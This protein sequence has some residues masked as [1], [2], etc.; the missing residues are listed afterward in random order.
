MS[1]HG[2]LFRRNRARRSILVACLAVCLLP[3][4]LLAAA[5]ANADSAL[6]RSGRVDTPESSPND[7]TVVYT[8]IVQ[9]LVAGR[10]KATVR[11]ASATPAPSRYVWVYVGEYSG[12]SCQVRAV[13]AG[14][15]ATNDAAGSFYGGDA[16]GVSRTRS[17]ATM[18]LTSAV[19]AQFGTAAYDCAW[20]QIWNSDHTSMLQDFEVAD[21]ETN[22]RPK[23]TIGG[24]AEKLQAAA[25]GRWVTMRMEVYNAG[26]S[27]GFGVKITAS[28]KGLKIKR[29][30]HS[31]GSIGDGITKRATFK[32]RVKKGTKKHKVTFK[33]T[34]TGG[35]TVKRT[36]TIGVA[37][38]PK[39][40][41]SLA[42]RYFWGFA[43]TSIADY[44]GWD[45]QVMW[46]LNNRWVHFGET[47]GGAVPKCRKVNRA[48]KTYTYNPRTGVAKIGKVKFK[49]SSYGY[50][51][52]A[53]DQKKRYYEA[54]T[55]PKKGKR[56]ATSLL[57]RDWYGNCIMTCTSFTNYL[58]MDRK[59]R[60]QRGGYS[61]GSWPALGWSWSTIPPNQRGKY[62]IISKG[63]IEFRYADGRRVRSRI[64]L[65]HN[66]LN[67][68]SAAS[69]I[70][71]GA[72]NYYKG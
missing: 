35:K 15:S 65:M 9:D 52:K 48:C 59:G 36:Y 55:F 66:A 18:T 34:A 8:D 72:T 7:G 42:G 60:F 64:A 12:S 30:S 54:V 63:R 68:P 69:G 13:F 24:P 43:S 58:T 70:V 32:V 5:P 21:L 37:P 45:N 17:G 29:K 51:Y 40:F 6:S 14:G 71:L 19:Q 1:L 23:L 10:L 22:W 53:P 50:V 11:F 47:K 33:V 16:F 41:K 4:T 25:K 62:R 3:F 56:F 27:D 38:K 39:R 57:N 2:Y 46:F 44:S 26:D 49:V 28:G 31:L 20:V 67:K 61:V